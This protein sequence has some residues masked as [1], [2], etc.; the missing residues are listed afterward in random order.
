MFK[1]FYAILMGFSILSDMLSKERASR[2]EL[3]FWKTI[4]AVAILID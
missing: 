2:T 1:V 4:A 3:V